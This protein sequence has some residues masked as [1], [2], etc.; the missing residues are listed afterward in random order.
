M[1]HTLTLLLPVLLLYSCQ[2]DAPKSSEATAKPIKSGVEILADS[3]PV[4]ED[5]L[6]NFQFSIHVYTND[7]TANG[8]Y[9]VQTEWGPNIATTT[10]CMPDGGE[11][12]K[13]ILRRGEQPY[14]YVIGFCYDADTAF[15]EFYQVQGSRGEIKAR[16]LKSYTFE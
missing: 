1:K 11:N 13:P 16:Y 10:M 5:K 3:L 15:N 9:D 14:T 2:S 4:L 8:Y 12:L 6:N 7:K